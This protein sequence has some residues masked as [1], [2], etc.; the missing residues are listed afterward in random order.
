MVKIECFPF[1]IENKARKSALITLIQHITGST[2]HCKKARKKP[3]TNK[4]K[5]AYRLKRKDKKCLYMIAYIENSKNCTKK[6]CRTN[7]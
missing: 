6:S 4:Q 2:S 1:K 5:K 3:K 7:K